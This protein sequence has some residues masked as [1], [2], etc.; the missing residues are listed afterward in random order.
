MARK[1]R[2]ASALEEAFVFR[3]GIYARLSVEDGD[4]IEQNSIGNQKRLCSEYL[5]E[6]KLSLTKVYT[7]HGYSG[8]LAQRP[9]LQEML[10]DAENGVINCIIVKDIS[11]LGRNFIATAELVEKILPRLKI[12]LICIND[13]Y[14]SIDRNSDASAL[15]LPLRMVMNDHYARDISKKIRSSIQA[16]MSDGSYLPSSSSIPFGYLR[17]AAQGTYDI[18]EEAAQVV[19]LIFRLRASGMKFNTIARILNDLHIPCPGRLRYQRGQTVAAK[20]ETAL[21]LRGTIRKMT[22]DEVYLGKRVYGKYRRPMLTAPKRPQEKHLWQTVEHGH[23]PI[24]SE[25]LF[26][27]VQTVNAK[28][29]EAR[30]GFQKHEAVS[31]ELRELLK[32]KVFCGDCGSRMHQRKACARKNATTSSRIFYDC[33]SYKN[34]N[35]SRCSCHYISQ[36]NILRAIHSTLQT[37]LSLCTDKL[38]ALFSVQ[39]QLQEK[40]QAARQQEIQRQVQNWED[41]KRRLFEDY[42]EGLLD[43]EEF[44]MQRQKYED[45]LQQLK[46]ESEQEDL[47]RIKTAVEETEQWLKQLQSWSGQPTEAQL[48]ALVEKIQVFSDKRIQLHLRFRDPFEVIDHAG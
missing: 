2:F 4:D 10:S 35:G 32:G 41:K 47:Q 7:D 20:Y 13:G 9:A 46:S 18:D 43:R 5:Q 27:Q 23:L 30:A 28:E 40:T 1:S 3:V 15:T 31:T 45:K 33:G 16:K 26:A 38:Q 17:N 37:Q 39:T 34:T 29:L 36:E 14:D 48:D 24:I 25:K 21:W 11:R 19:C 12:R 8:M 6:H 42:A 44:F 22:K